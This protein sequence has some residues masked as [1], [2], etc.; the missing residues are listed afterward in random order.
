MTDSQ[1]LSTKSEGLCQISDRLPRII[2]DIRKVKPPDQE[3]N[4]ILRHPSVL[5]YINKVF[6]VSAF[7]KEVIAGARGLRLLTHRFPTRMLGRLSLFA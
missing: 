2:F 1:V 4:V 3:L 6:L 5:Y 7:L